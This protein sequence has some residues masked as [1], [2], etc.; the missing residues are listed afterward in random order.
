MNCKHCKQPIHVVSEEERRSLIF[1]S[2]FEY[3]HNNNY[4]GCGEFGLFAEPESLED[5]LKNPET[6]EAVR[7][8]QQE[9]DNAAHEL[10]NVAARFLDQYNGIELCAGLGHIRE[11]WRELRELAAENRRKQE[12]FL[13]ALAPQS[14]KPQRGNPDNRPENPRGRDRS[15][16]QN[17]D[18]QNP[19]VEAAAE[20]IALQ[21][22]I[23]VSV[24][25]HP[26]PTAAD[27]SE[28]TPARQNGDLESLKSIAQADAVFSR[29]LGGKEGL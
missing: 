19:L 20:A 5:S 22:P 6:A 13:R 28:P 15:V 3:K 14:A 10:A 26:H 7:K 11:D 24:V 1:A 27:A 8:A 12:A 2:P 18:R 25:P 21:E 17:P 29:L 16:Y 4:W 9:W 23:A